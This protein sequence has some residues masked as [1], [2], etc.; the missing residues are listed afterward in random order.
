MI[1][2]NMTRLLAVV[3]LAQGQAPSVANGAQPVADAGSSRY[4]AQDP[5]VLDGTG[6][7]T[8][9]NSGPLSYTWRQISGPPAVITDANTATPMVGGFVQTN[10]IQ[11]CEFELVVSDGQY[12]SLPDTVEVRIVP[13]FSGIRIVL[14][15]E[16][17]DPNKPTI[18]YFGGGDGING[19]PAYAQ[20]PL[21]DPF[22]SQKANLLSFPD[23]YRVDN[24][25]SGS[26]TYDHL[27]D[28]IIST[29]SARARDYK[30]PIQTV[31]WSTGGLPAVKVA[32][33][34]NLTYQDRRYAVNRVTALDAAGPGADEMI[35]QL[36]AS[37]VDGE[38]C[39][40]ES[41]VSTS[42]TFYTN[43]LN[44]GFSGGA[45]ALPRDWFGNSLTTSTANQFNG[46]VVGGAY[47]SVIGPGK[48]LQLADTPGK[49]NYI[50]KW[51]GS[52][53]SGYMDFFN[54]VSYSGGLPEP[55]TLVGPADGVF[56]DANGAVF[57]CEASENAEGYQLLFGSDPYRVMDY[58]IISHT[59]TPPKEVITTFPFEKTW[60]TVKVR[61]QFGSTIYAD[62][63]HVYAENVAPLVQRIQNA[64]IGTGYDSIQ[65]AIDEAASGD[66]IVVDRGIFFESID[67]MGKGLTL[68]STDPN[69]P[70]IAASTII[71]ASG[72]AVTFSSSEDASCVLSGFTITDA[73]NGIYCSG[74]SPTITS[75]IITNNRNTGIELR[76]A[77]NP[78]MINCC[79]A[80]NAGAG[81][82]MMANNDGR[83]P[84]YNYPTVTN[85][86][87]V[88]NLQNGISGGKP[89]IIDSIIWANSPTQI[90][91]TLNAVSIIFSDVQGD[92]AGEG[93]IDA[94]P[95]F[96]DPD[97]GDY[98]LKSQAGRWDIRTQT[99]VTD[100]MTSPCIDAGD[101]GFPVGDEPF[102][103]GSR[104]NM[105][106]YG[107]TN[108]A[109]NSNTRQ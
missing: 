24:G 57:S 50:F 52:A 44:V 60:W 30:K 12:E 93:N 103:N 18:I 17:F 74:S 58:T 66:E 109:S 86:T 88:G 9:D 67:F 8:P 105:G 11:G 71:S 53:S 104:I 55:V 21:N 95:F 80:A 98:H 59:P 6:S 3:V 56:V 54:Q 25:T 26:P 101:P 94:D 78:I 38:Q 34:L 48:N 77:S 29:L 107:G 76:S 84:L 63:I 47:W 61:D 64:T 102:P 68:R 14:A 41:Y 82:G 85:C 96:A 36:L 92:F 90:S 42:D 70:T 45:H 7:Y 32:T 28:A 31:G 33:Y 73:N 91:D 5:V 23:G 83:R 89:I 37:S 13:F 10:A 99:W 27:G 81:I 4:V 62:P 19:T 87:I 2:M 75:C 15:N 79:I 97:K 51:Y 16:S 69:D 65:Q 40:L 43:I 1:L 20:L 22:W 46:G 49:S 39:W 72:N 100:D 35:S 106:T 108:H